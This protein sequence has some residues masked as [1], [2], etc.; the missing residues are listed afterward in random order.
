MDVGSHI[1][2][3]SKHRDIRS[4]FRPEILFS[5][6]SL[7]RG[8]EKVTLCTSQRMENLV[9]YGLPQGDSK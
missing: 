9:Q 7:L 8:I 5:D 2:R 6:K 3:K 4:P 1:G